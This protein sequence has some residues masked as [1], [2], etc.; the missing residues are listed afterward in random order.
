MARQPVTC[1]YPTVS[2]NH[3]LELLR[4]PLLELGVRLT[5][6]VTGGLV[7][8]QA[9]LRRVQTVSPQVCGLL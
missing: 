6:A 1:G 9:G 4:S 3:P 2:P 8:S 5:L 7:E